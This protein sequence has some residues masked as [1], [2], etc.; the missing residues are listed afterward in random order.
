[1]SEISQ[2]TRSE[3]LEPAFIRYKM[4]YH[5]YVPRLKPYSLDPTAA[6]AVVCATCPLFMEVGKAGF[7]EPPHGKRPD[8]LETKYQAMLGGG[9]PGGRD[10]V[11]CKAYLRFLEGVGHCLAHAP[12]SLELGSP[13]LTHRSW[14]CGA[15]AG[16]NEV[17]K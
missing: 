12:G 13:G 11:N 17:E 16:K 3:R 6:N 15:Y 7:R 9:S 5:S 10:E 14:W 4:A 1:M 8:I 2:T